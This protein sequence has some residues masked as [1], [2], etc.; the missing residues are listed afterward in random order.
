[1]TF[2]QLIQHVGTQNI[3]ICTDS[4]AIRAGDVFV[5]I[6]GNALDGHAFITDA[7]RRGARYIVYEQPSDVSMPGIKAIAVDNG[8]RAAALLTQAAMGRPGSQL[9]NLAVT[10]TNGKTTVAFLVH[11]CLQVAGQSCGLISTIAYDTG[12]ACTPATLTTPDCIMMAHMQAQ[13]VQAGCRLMVTEASSHALSQDRL[14]G[15]DFSAAAFTNLSGD[16]LDYHHTEQAYLAA[17]TRLFTDLSGQAT[18]VLNQQSP[19]A[20]TIAQQT[21]AKLL[22]YAIDEQ[23]DLE[24]RIKS[25]DPRGTLYDLYYQGRHVQMHSPLL[26]RFNVSNHLA[27]AGLCI[28]AGLDLHSIAQGLASLTSIPGRLERI[29]GPDDIMILI[30]YAHTDDALY[31]VLAT[32][33]PLCRGRLVT[34]FG[35]GGD[36]DRTKRPRMAAAAQAF[37]DKVLLTSDNPRTE[38]PQQIIDD[39]LQGFSSDKRPQVTIEPNRRNAIAMAL[40]QA[41]PRDIILIAG[42]GHETYQIIGDRKYPFSDKDVVQDI[43]QTTGRHL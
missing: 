26:G 35:C 14:A 1:M 28:T 3:T 43:L 37:S 38:P 4:R 22:W 36:R 41:Q 42:K 40:D 12:Q 25:M 34:V 17:K 15:I 8:H 6:K 16:H 30:D 29:D 7:V 27:A 24:G 13:M 5:A 31:H 9:T 21:R 32:L 2:D 11:H 19:H 20:R 18:A 23:A 10:G 33:R 39:I